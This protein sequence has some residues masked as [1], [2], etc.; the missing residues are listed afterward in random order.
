[1]IIRRA[2]QK[3][4]E[5]LMNFYEKMCKHLGQM[6]FL[7]NGNR[8]GFPSE[9]MVSAAIAGNEQYVGIEDDRIVAA[10]IINHDCDSTYDSVKWQITVPREKVV[11]LHALR[12]LPEYGG[13]GYSKMLLEH[14][15]NVAKNSGQRAIRL[16]C[17]VGNEIPQKMYL[18]YGF[19]YIDT[20]QITYVDIGEPKNFRLYEYVF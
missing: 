1:M 19:K 5:E 13:R 15:M 2:L 3:D 18:A 12:V 14:A 6:K 20:V 7:P 9:E 16:D 4:F 10:Y 8:G 17:L 11:T